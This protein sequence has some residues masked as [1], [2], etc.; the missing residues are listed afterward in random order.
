MFEKKS[1]WCAPIKI[2]STRFFS[3]RLELLLKVFG[4]TRH[5]CS[6]KLAHYISLIGLTRSSSSQLK[7]VVLEISSLNFTVR[8]DPFHVRVDSSFTAPKSS[9]CLLCAGRP[10]QFMGRLKPYA[11]SYIYAKFDS[12]AIR[13]NLTLLIKSYRSIHSINKHNLTLLSRL[14]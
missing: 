7:I 12:F 5:Y 4:L 13:V 8:V 2:E 3:S 14:T 1:H 6:E 9:F 10:R 11:K